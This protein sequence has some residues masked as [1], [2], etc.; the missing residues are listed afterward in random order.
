MR[1]LLPYVL[2]CLLAVTIRAAYV[3]KLD[4]YL[5]AGGAEMERAAASVAV[6]GTI[7]DVYPG[8]SGRSAHVAPLYPLFLG[9]LYALFG[10]S[11]IAGRVVQE[12]CAI[13]ATIGAFLL[14]PS[15]ARRTGLSVVAAWTAA[16]ALAVL[17][18]NLWIE[19]SGTWEQPYAGL[20]ILGFLLWFARND[21]GP[22]SSPWL[23]ST[24]I[25][26]AVS[27][28]LNPMLLPVGAVMAWLALRAAGGLRRHV[29]GS[30]ALVLT[31]TC[32][33]LAPWALRNYVAL[34]GFVPV[35]SNFGLELALGNNDSADGR[36]YVGGWDDTRR[37][38]SVRHP[39]EHDGER[40]RL[41]EIG[42]YAY[43]K[44]RQHE[45][46]H[47][48]GT[49]PAEFIE[50]T[51]HR[52]VLYWF[53]PPNLWSSS[54]TGRGVKSLIFVF[55]GAAAFIELIWLLVVRQRQALLLSAAAM[56]PG[57]PYFVTHVDPRYRYPVFALS[58]LLAFDLLWRMSSK[59]LLHRKRDGLSVNS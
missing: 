52:F 55:I 10:T 25:L 42:E 37:L 59:A 57:L 36:T 50:L 40:R 2:L 35:R 39:F 14:L 29:L 53:P 21:K 5:P 8:V 32:I 54:S 43:M 49:H 48:I 13:A 19:S 16:F 51:W 47:W 38:E 27:A 23:P 58:T 11:T 7:G 33:T 17:P 30:F 46:L 28:L 34:G 26:L 20:T 15:V 24:G 41:L 9:S 3:M 12:A 4:L 18:T 56:L 22:P 1:K 44:D 6:R 45:A 31:V